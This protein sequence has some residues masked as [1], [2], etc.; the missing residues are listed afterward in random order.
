MCKHD[1]Y[2]D[3]INK[4]NCELIYVQEKI[5]Q[6]KVDLNAIYDFQVKHNQFSNMFH[7]QIEEETKKMT[8]NSI[9]KYGHRFIKEYKIHMDTILFGQDTIQILQSIEEDKNQIISIIDEL[10]ENLNLLLRK[11]YNLEHEL[12]S[13]H[14][15]IKKEEVY[16]G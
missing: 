6:L 13:Y 14:Y 4:N 5:K 10:E 1:Y 7:H 3:Q 16:N 12:S 11:K 9:T 15:L 8:S 2:Q